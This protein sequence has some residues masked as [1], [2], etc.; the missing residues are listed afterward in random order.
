MEINWN[1]T[2]KTTKKKLD[3]FL[4][5]IYNEFEKIYQYC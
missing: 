5:T 4:Y 2:D 1:D 3:A